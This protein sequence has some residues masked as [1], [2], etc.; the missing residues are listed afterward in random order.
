M[1]WPHVPPQLPG[2]S[3]P[4]ASPPRCPQEVGRGAAPTSACLWK[5]FCRREHVFWC[6]GRHQLPLSYSGYRRQPGVPPRPHTR[7][8]GWSALSRTSWVWLAQCKDSALTNPP[9]ANFTSAESEWTGCSCGGTA[10]GS[11]VVTQSHHCHDSGLGGAVPLPGMSSGDS[12]RAHLEVLRAQPWSCCRVLAWV[13]GSST[14]F[15][16]CEARCHQASTLCA[17]I[18]TRLGTP[19]LWCH[20][21]PPSSHPLSSSCLGEEEFG[22]TEDGRLLCG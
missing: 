10:H 5:P 2:L 15:K 3:P 22:V 4:A 17:T 8:Q 9:R 18:P 6:L 21:I 20:Q 1:R 16:R 13:T 11:R 12:L 19:V 14:G 7:A